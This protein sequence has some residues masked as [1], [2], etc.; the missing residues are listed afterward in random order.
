M[1]QEVTHDAGSEESGTFPACCKDAAEKMAEC[2]PMMEKMMAHCGPMM[3]KMM[4]SFGAKTSGSES[5]GRCAKP[6]EP[7]AG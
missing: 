6:E 1:T 7:A 5:D 3:Q 4:G 2:G